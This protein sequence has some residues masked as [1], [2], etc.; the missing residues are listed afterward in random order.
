MYIQ[1]T[2]MHTYTYTSYMHTHAH[3]YT[4]IIIIHIT[5]YMH[6]IMYVYVCMMYIQ[7]VSSIVLGNN[8]QLCTLI[9]KVGVYVWCVK[10][11]RFCDISYEAK[12]DHYGQGDPRISMF[13]TG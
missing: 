13:N 6:T 7:R 11:Y 3:N 10:Y 2:Y 9:L 1:V 12:D 4:N 5:S 8:I